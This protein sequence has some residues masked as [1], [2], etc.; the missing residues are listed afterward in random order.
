M[1]AFA[2]MEERVSEKMFFMKIAEKR[3][4]RQMKSKYG[5]LWRFRCSDSEMWG[6]FK[7]NLSELQNKWKEEQNDI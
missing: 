3:A 4:E 5:F 1:G 6:A 2:D 7:S